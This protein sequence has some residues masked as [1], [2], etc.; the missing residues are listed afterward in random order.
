MEASGLPDEIQAFLNEATTR[1]LGLIR[2][3]IQTKLRYAQTQDCPYAGY[4]D[5]TIIVK[6]DF[7][8]V[9][10][11]LRILSLIFGPAVKWCGIHGKE[12]Y[13]ITFKKSDR[14]ATIIAK[15]HYWI[16]DRHVEVMSTT[17]FEASP[18]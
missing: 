18:K 13:F 15:R 1:Q 8:I 14:M 16:T 9:E 2:D 3:I 17:E 12:Y 6:S 11:D 4:E 10:M 5:R 7:N